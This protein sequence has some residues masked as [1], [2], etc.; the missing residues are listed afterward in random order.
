[1]FDPAYIVRNNKHFPMNST[2]EISLGIFDIN[3]T[4]QDKN[5]VPKE[6]IEGFK[7][8]GRN[9][10]RTTIATGRG[11]SRAKQLLGDALHT[12]VSPGMP[13]SVENGSRLATLDGKNIAHHTLSPDVRKSS[14]DIIDSERDD[15][16]FVAHYPQDNR[17]GISLWTPNGE[18]PMS[19][20]QRHGSFGEIYTDSVSDLDARVEADKAGMLIIK[21]RDTEL[22]AAFTGANVEINETELNILNGSVN[23]GR[24]V[25]DIAEY[26]GVPLEEISVAGNDYNDLSMLRLATGRKFFVGDNKIDSYSDTVIRLATP[27]LLGAYLSTLYSR[28]F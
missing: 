1:M 22:A 27:A 10:L 15:I 23:K 21:P 24:G 5:G 12:V 9:G 20:T 7:A 8:M 17:R 26:T 2:H 13:I 19:F 16:E 11:V 18:V 14:L 25:Q 3:G 6:V 28:T 4:I